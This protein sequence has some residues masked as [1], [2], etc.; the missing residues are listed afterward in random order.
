MF[1]SFP[2]ERLSGNA[3]IL[4]KTSL[5]RF[6]VLCKFDKNNFNELKIYKKEMKELGLLKKE[7]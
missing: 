5:N 7:F 4:I 1:S 3:I 2:T 6:T